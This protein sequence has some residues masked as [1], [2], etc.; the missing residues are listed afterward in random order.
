MVDTISSWTGNGEVIDTWSD[1]TG[2]VEK[3]RANRWIFRGQGNAEH[4]L[5]PGI[6]R[7]G[8]RKNLDSGDELPFDEEQEFGMLKRFRREIR[9]HFAT[10]PRP[11]VRTDW[12]LMA[13][14]QHH[15]LKTRLLDWSESPLVA[16]Y[17]AVSSSGISGGSKVDAALFGISC[18]YVI[19]T[20]TEKWPSEHDVVAF[21][22]PHLTPRITVQHGLFTIHR[23]PDQPWQP[24][25]L[26]KW[27]IPANSCLP[28]KL[29]LHRAGLNQASL[30]PDADGI[31]AHLNW[32]HKWDLS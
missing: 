22:P 14:A 4:G 5:V 32:L 2:L 29:A 8:S 6:G 9:P 20:E 31:A 3:Y 12:D 26:R 21:Y 27:T 28:I 30:F 16:A 13:I 7:P 17:F 24:T 15:G 18:P 11:H 23:S 1:L 10:P 19:E 25:G